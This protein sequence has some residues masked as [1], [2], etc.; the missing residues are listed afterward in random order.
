MKKIKTII[1][2][3]LMIVSLILMPQKVNASFGI[4]T[5]D[6]YSKGVYNDYLHFGNTG[7]VFNYVVYLK[8]GI[9]YPAYCLNKDLDGITQNYTYSVNTEELLSNVKIWRAIINGYPYKTAAELGCNTNEEAF[10]ATKQAVYCMLYDRNPNE[11][12]AYDEREQRVLNALTQ[13]VTNANNSSQIKQNANLE[14]IDVTSKWEQDVVD[15]KYIS[16]VFS[17]SSNAPI[18]TYTINIEN[19]NIEGAK[20]VNE[21]NEETMEF[22]QGE[23]FK[24]LIPITNMQTDGSFNINVVGQVATKPVLYGYST[25][26]SMQDYAITGTIYE[27]GDGTKTDYYWKNNTKIII[28]K[29]DEKENKLEGVKFNLLNENKEI[30]YADLTT[31]QNGEITINNLLPAKYY[32]EEISTLKGFKTI[33]EPIEVNVGYNEE[34]KVKVTNKEEIIEIEKPETI[35]KEKDAIVKLPKT[36]M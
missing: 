24:I 16:K 6:L 34:L 27:E 23:N 5:A 26:R 10:I 3:V 12:N 35:N 25:N 14:I 22:K 20:I 17:V 32:I 9:E 11:Y 28:I 15:T 4:E 1:T 7:I 2:I 13:I 21:Q 31:N 8:D 19:M 36:G 29:E 30:M 33:N 18:N